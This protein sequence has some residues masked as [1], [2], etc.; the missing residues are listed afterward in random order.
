[1]QEASILA[2]PLLDKEPMTLEF[3][4]F[5]DAKEAVAQAANYIFT[6]YY[7]SGYQKDLPCAESHINEAL[8][9]IGLYFYLVSSSLKSISLYIFA[10]SNIQDAF[11]FDKILWRKRKVPIIC[12]YII[13]YLTLKLKK[14]C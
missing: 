11:C 5:S 13:C 12:H 8:K 7:M 1:M 3:A 10:H 4:S 2:S 6:N 9:A 14:L